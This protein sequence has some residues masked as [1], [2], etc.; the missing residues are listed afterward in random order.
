M[1]ATLGHLEL[2]I[3]LGYNTQYIAGLFIDHCGAYGHWQHQIFTTAAGTFGTAALLAIFSFKIS[4]VTEIDQGIKAL[5][6]DQNNTAA[7]T[8]V[9]TIRPAF[10]NIFFTAKTQTAIAALTRVNLD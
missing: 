1:I 3:K 9:T 5:G 4:G 6:A 8:T 2:L 10:G 7:I